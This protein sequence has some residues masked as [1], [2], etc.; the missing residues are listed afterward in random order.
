M[1]KTL[2]RKKACLYEPTTS[3]AIATTTWL[4]GRNLTLSRGYFTRQALQAGVHTVVA[5]KIVS[6]A[7][8]RTKVNRCMQIILNS[9]FHYIIPRVDGSEEDGT[10]FS[11]E[12]GRT[13]VLGD[14]DALLGGLPLPWTGLDVPNEIQDFE[15]E[16]VVVADADSGKRSSADGGGEGG[17]NKR[18]VLLCFNENV[19]SAHDVFRCHNE[20]IRDAANGANL[21]LS[22]DEWRWFFSGMSSLSPRLDAMSGSPLIAGK[23]GAPST[24][25]TGS[26]T[27]SVSPASMS[28]AGVRPASA[29]SDMASIQPLDLDST[30]ASSAL[31]SSIAA[32]SPKLSLLPRIVGTED[33]DGIAGGGSNHTCPPAAP[34]P[35]R[36]VLGELTPVDLAKFRTTWC[37]KR[38]EH[39]PSVCSFAHVEMN[40]GWLR[41]DPVLFK[42]K[43]EMCPYIVPAALGLHTVPPELEGCNVNSCPRGMNC[44]LAHSIEEVEYHP[45]NYK[46]IL[47]S[48]VLRGQ[49]QTLP[50]QACKLRDICPHLH[51]PGSSQPGRH[52]HH[53]G[54]QGPGR[55]WGHR[56][57]GSGDVTAFGRGQTP[58]ATSRLSQEHTG[59]PMLYIH[60]APTSEFDRHL[61]LPGLRELFRHKCSSTYNFYHCGLTQ[62]KDD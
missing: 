5:S 35:T 8:T 14:E 57:Q 55:Q 17:G 22:A 19:R 39:H 6:K 38:Y 44:H 12:F 16:G 32:A 37:S 59:A 20:F 23:A 33:G 1:L 31:S 49:D 25:S 18:S 13:A 41:R 43:G 21:L 60:P 34:E 24:V 26:S 2:L 52:Y 46:T 50:R 28:P 56:R 30:A 27:A 54:G 48:S 10:A 42:Y 53:H 4:V 62:R 61:Q 3:H 58:I 47:C 11:A 45:D 29:E 15:E 40:G 9:C 36:D 7:I 51:P